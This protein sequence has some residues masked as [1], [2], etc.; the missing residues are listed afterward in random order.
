MPMLRDNSP[1]LYRG[2]SKGRVVGYEVRGEEASR[3][4]VQ[5]YDQQF[6]TQ[7]PGTHPISADQMPKTVFIRR[8]IDKL[9]DD[10]GHSFYSVRTG[11]LFVQ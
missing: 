1:N 4:S 11:E 5:V 8:F 10:L 9:A 6:S 7:H 2:R 3:H